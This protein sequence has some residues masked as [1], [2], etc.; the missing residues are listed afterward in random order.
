MTDAQTKRLVEDTVAETI[1]QL[2]AEGLLADTSP[3]GKTEELLRQYPN[4]YPAEPAHQAIDAFLTEQKNDP[5]IKAIWLYYFTGNTSAATAATLGSTERTC[6][7]NRLRLVD[8]LAAKLQ[9]A[10]V[11]K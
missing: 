2:R 7:R 6:R 5:Y 11:I 9:S 8:L 4:M 3:R 1:R 10:G